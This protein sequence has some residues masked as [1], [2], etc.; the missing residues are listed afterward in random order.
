MIQAQNKTTVKQKRAPI[1]AIRVK[2]IVKI[3]EPY[4]YWKR[5]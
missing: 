1:P 5:I 3:V 4:T 2:D